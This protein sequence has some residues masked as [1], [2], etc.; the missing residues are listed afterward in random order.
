MRRRTSFCISSCVSLNHNLAV[1]VNI[2]LYTTTTLARHSQI[3]DQVCWFHWER[4][5]AG[6]ERHS[7]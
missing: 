5:P 7:A 6:H 3:F 1:Q 4:F 2:W